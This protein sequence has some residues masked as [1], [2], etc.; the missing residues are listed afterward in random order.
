M[1]FSLFFALLFLVSRGLFELYV[2]K[3]M[4]YMISIIGFCLFLLPFYFKNIHLEKGLIER[5]YLVLF[6]LVCSLGSLLMSLSLGLNPV[7]S[8]YL[9]YPLVLSFTF[10]IAFSIVPES[11]SRD[12]LSNSISLLIYILFLVALLQQLFLIDLPGVTYTFGVLIRPSSLTGSYLHYPLIMALL[13][14]ILISL[15]RKLSFSSILAL[16]SSFIAFSRS[17]MMLVVLTTFFVV[18]LY[19]FKG[20]VKV[21]F[22]SVFLFFSLVVPVFFLSF[23]MG[24]LDLILE[25]MF[26]SVS[27]SSSGNEGRIEAW[28]IGFDIYTSTNLLIG[29]H[30]GT[31]TNLTSNLTSAEANVV[32]SGFIQNL[33]NFGLL[34]TVAFYMLFIYIYLNALSVVER[35]FIIAFFAQSFV[36]QSIEVMPFIIGLI[37]LFSLTVRFRK[38]L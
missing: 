18:I 4:A 38:S 29:E 31:I 20:R 35:G 17:G 27:T 25:R 28:K 21:N 13:A 7:Y 37:F 24:W 11:I 19:L 9:I 22:K 15:N 32:E 34:G 30:F 6:F 10:L 33:I 8:V 5:V 36:Y 23:M 14:V 1:Y 3:S 26:S 2:A 12:K 16:A